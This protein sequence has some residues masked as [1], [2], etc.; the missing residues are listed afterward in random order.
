MGC[1]THFL[2]WPG[3]SHM[4]KPFFLALR[5]GVA[6]AAQQSTSEDR[7]GR[8]LRITGLISGG[9]GRAVDWAEAGIPGFESVT[10][11]IDI[12]LLRA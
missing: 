6:E 2:Q 9:P 11:M 5:P 3:H 4:S 7:L 12:G 1:G 10:L 8:R